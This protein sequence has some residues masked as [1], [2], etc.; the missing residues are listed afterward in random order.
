ME[1]QCVS[2]RFMFFNGRITYTVEYT[3]G[4]AT[5]FVFADDQRSDA[6]YKYKIK[7]KHSKTPNRSEAEFIL[8]FY[9]T[10]KEK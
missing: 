8:E 3:Y 5:W 2:A 1:Y 6:L 7:P 9:L 4:L 10:G